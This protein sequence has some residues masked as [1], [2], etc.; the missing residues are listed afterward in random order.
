MIWFIVTITIII[1]DIIIIIIIIIIMMIMIMIMSMLIGAVEKSE[2]L[3]MLLS[4]LR[5]RERAAKEIHG[6]INGL[7][8]P[9]D[10]IGG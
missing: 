9:R 10:P 1:Y 8:E 5:D 4:G 7:T 6:Q 2:P 3:R